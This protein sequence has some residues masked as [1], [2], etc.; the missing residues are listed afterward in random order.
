MNRVIDTHVHVGTDDEGEGQSIDEL[1][2]RMREAGITHAVIFPFSTKNLLA[3]SEELRLLIA[4]NERFI[5]LLRIDPLST[6]KSEIARV[7]K[8]Y[9]GIKLHP[10]AQRFDI[11]DP[12]VAF[13]YEIANE[14][15]LPIL[16][17]TKEA[18][19]HSH[20]LKAISIAQAYPKTKIILGHF[21]G[22]S[23]EAMQRAR[24]VANVYAETSIFG[25]SL[26]IK[27]LVHEGFDR[28]LFGS[29]SPY[30]DQLAA[31]MTIRRSGI[32]HES[33][34][35]IV[36]HNPAEVFSNLSSRDSQSP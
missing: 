6:T 9:A 31:L 10:N 23:F 25:R 3:R 5:P 33:Y 15:E 32:S 35:R 20:P 2:E 22:D 18:Q 7:A 30:D 4:G 24:T 12:R 28:M 8:Q 21:F 17:H 36:S 16:F 34:E 29:D 11:E 1:E 14:L 27:Q 13:I 26:R 19:P